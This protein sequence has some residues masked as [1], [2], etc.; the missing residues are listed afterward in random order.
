MIWHGL[1]RYETVWEGMAWYGKVRDGVEQY[2]EGMAQ[3][4][5][6]QNHR[7]AWY[8]TVWCGMGQYGMV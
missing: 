2:W 5:T 1:G 8:G 6:V 3:H 4:G 7:I